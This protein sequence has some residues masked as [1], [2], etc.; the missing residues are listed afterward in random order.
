MSDLAKRKTAFLQ[1]IPFTSINSKIVTSKC[2]ILQKGKRLFL[3]DIPFTSI[4]I[5]IIT[6]K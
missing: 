5:N 1:D 4:N 2:A 6:S 3:Q